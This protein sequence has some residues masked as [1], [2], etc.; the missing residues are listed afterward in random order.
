M[1]A[2]NAIFLITISTVATTLAATNQTR[3]AIQNT[4]Q[5]EAVVVRAQRLLPLSRP[6]DRA[7][8]LDNPR[9]LNAAEAASQVPGVSGAYRSIDVPEVTIRGLG[10]ERVPVQIDYLPLYGSCPALMDPPATCISPEALASLTVVKGLPSVTY[11]SGGSG[12]RVMARTVADPTAPALNGFSAD[13]SAL[14][15]GGRDGVSGGAGGRIGNGTIEAGISANA[16]DYGD[17]QS[18]NGRRVPAKN[19]SQGAS[20]GIRFTPD[21]NNG[22][23]GSWSMHHVDELDYPTLPMDATDVMANTLTLGGRHESVG[24]TLEDI[25]WLV[26]YS[27]SDH[28]MDNSRKPN[29]PMMDAE[30]ITEAET[31]GIRLAT[32]WRFSEQSKWV[33]GA[34]AHRIARDGTRTRTVKVA[35]PPPG[36]YQDPIWPDATQ[37]QFG[38]FAERSTSLANETRL[39]LGF[40]A[41]AIGSAIG[42]GGESTPFDPTVIDGYVKYYG[43]D[44]RD[45]DRTEFLFS[46]NAL[47]EIPQGDQFEWYL[48]AGCVQRAASI[49][50]RFYAYAPAPGGFQV[51]NPT[52]DPET[53]AE[54]DA[55]CDVFGERIEL[56]FH[57]FGSYIWNY[58]LETSIGNTSNGAP[59]RG[60]V[61]ADALL[62]GG[63]IEG[64]W[65]F[66]D[67]WS[68][69][70]SMAYVR[71]RNL[72]DN[73]DLPLMPPLNG[74]IALRWD[75]TWKLRPWCEAV[76]RAAM[77]QDR[78]DPQ[79]GE[80]ATPGYQVFDLRT[81]LRLP[82]GFGIELGVENLFDQDYAEHLNREVPLAVGDL[83]RGE[84]VPM[85]GRF[86]YA[87]VKWSI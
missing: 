64:R 83:Q 79:F 13:A 54:L 73:R 33:T 43:A 32:G 69:P 26:G 75:S 50:E 20:A 51:G 60:F 63:E 5:L 62:F 30:A 46:G 10:W 37:A 35:P 28:T 68:I 81:G 7:E 66:S 56:G 45:T 25:E 53:K 82:G 38:L 39:R 19:K 29:Q 74:R 1:K 17:Y 22:Y 34:D 47:W 52:L 55:G 6:M 85:P 65:K 11:G 15:N 78:I 40:R 18:G 48:G 27:L 59:V 70:F 8:L 14:W 2:H 84:K 31:F 4:H 61:N 42:R 49:T 12:G 67:A 58:I 23:F 3:Q 36:T 80:S 24:T 44:A 16:I 9:I 21:P 41:D 71:G 77:E 72:D 76:L 86:F 57:L 87:G